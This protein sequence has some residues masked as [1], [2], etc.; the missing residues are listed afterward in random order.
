MTSTSPT[1]HDPF[2][3]LLTEALRAGPGSAPWGEAVA[4]LRD[5][6]VDGADEYAVL[7]RAREDIQM[8]RDYR[9]VSAGPGFT[10]KV[11]EAVEREGTRRGVPTATIVAIL[12]GLVILGVIITVIVIM[13]RGGTYGPIDRLEN[14]SMPVSIAAGAVP[15][16][17]SGFAVTEDKDAKRPG[18]SLVTSQALDADRPAM[19]EC[20][21]VVPPT[22]GQQMIV[23]F[24]NDSSNTPTD[25][26]WTYSKGRAD[27]DLASNSPPSIALGTPGATLKA[28]IR[29]DREVAIIEAGGR[30]LYA[31]PH[32]LTA[33]PRH[34][35]MQIIDPPSGSAKSVE[36]KSI[37]V[38]QA[39][40]A[41]GR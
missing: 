25:V 22:D 11:L 38:A 10:R 5:G 4:R 41:G 28:S 14:V 18:K 9:K 32:H 36:I 39:A 1:E 24:V 13:S 37:S 26:Y 34:A 19:L 20:E 40:P 17:L 31:G 2:F 12:S 23:L 35:G 27:V 8:G 21:F 6:G 30:R 16:N 29:F 33:T 3:Q 7:L 15:G